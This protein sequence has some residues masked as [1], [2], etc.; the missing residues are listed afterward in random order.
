MGRG[1]NK[2]VWATVEGSI[3]S[4]AKEE[5]AQFFKPKT[6]KDNISKIGRALIDKDDSNTGQDED[7]MVSRP[8]KAKK[9]SKETDEF[10]LGKRAAL[11]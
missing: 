3:W 7:Q 8:R 6:P 1:L 9:Q 4:A 11:E 2:T 5:E 10:S